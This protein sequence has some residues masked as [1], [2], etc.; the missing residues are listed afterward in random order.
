MEPY[1]RSKYHSLEW[2][3]AESA[4]LDRLRDDAKDAIDEQTREALIYLAT[5][6]WLRDVRRG[7][8]VS[9]F[10]IWLYF[11]RYGVWK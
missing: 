7:R 6:E 9:D 4:R 2:E 11:E 3:I 1:T 8:V 10:D 5:A